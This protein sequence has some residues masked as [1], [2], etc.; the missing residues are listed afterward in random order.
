MQSRAEL[1]TLTIMYV[2]VIGVHCMYMYSG[3]QFHFHLYSC[4]LA[5]P[6]YL[7]AWSM[8][9]LLGQ[10][11]E[12]CINMQHFVWHAIQCNE[13]IHVHVPAA[14]WLSMSL[15]TGDDEVLNH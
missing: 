15:E 12:Y 7:G 1:L 6:T 2:Y 8:V 5:P 3:V 11:L 13:Y 9:W 10:P 4:K 14:N